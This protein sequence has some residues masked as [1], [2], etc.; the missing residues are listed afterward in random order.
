MIG[1]G[2]AGVASLQPRGQRLANPCCEST[3]LT[4]TGPGRPRLRRRQHLRPDAGWARRAP[5]PSRGCQSMG[6][7]WWRV[8]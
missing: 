8:R 1:D 6:Q 5:G 2:V 7:A 3:R 4:G